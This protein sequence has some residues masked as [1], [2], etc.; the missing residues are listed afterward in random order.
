MMIN[1]LLNNL[2]DLNEQEL[3]EK[4]INTMDVIKTMMDSC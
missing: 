1:L 3:K 4:Y 2:D